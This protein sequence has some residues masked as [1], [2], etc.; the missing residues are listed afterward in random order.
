M[1]WAVIMLVALAGFLGGGA[2]S[3]AKQGRRNAMWI[4]IVLAV[5]ACVAAVL[6][7][8]PSV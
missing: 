5:M 6:Y 1:S 8:W 2:Y 4:L 7:A 3:F